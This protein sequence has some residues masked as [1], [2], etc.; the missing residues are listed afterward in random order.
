VPK[1]NQIQVCLTAYAVGN[2]INVDDQAMLPDIFEL[3]SSG[4]ELLSDSP[5]AMDI[6]P[7][8][9]SPT[10]VTP[11][12]SLL[13]GP[14]AAMGAMAKVLRRNMRNMRKLSKE[15]NSSMESNI[16]GSTS[17]MDYFPTNSSI[18]MPLESLET[19]MS[20]GSRESGSDYVTDPI[21]I[22]ANY[23]DARP[24]VHITLTPNHTLPNGETVER[25]LGHI[26]LHF[27]KE[28]SLLF[29]SGTGLYGM[30]GFTHSVISE[31]YAIL[32]YVSLLIC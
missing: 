18:G 28:N 30:G 26:S 23:I 1:E 19:R 10:P 31:F 22:S 29:N 5:F 17:D 32:R 2:M 27:V 9:L 16:G 25:V 7:V 6:L 8:A 3:D 20:E 11:T 12:N 21:R 15:N 14:S 24:H 4:L 13:G